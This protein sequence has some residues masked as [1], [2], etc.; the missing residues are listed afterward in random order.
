MIDQNINPNNP[1]LNDIIDLNQNCLRTNL[2]YEQSHYV[3]HDFIRQQKQ[4]ILMHV[5][6][7]SLDQNSGNLK[8]LLNS[9]D[10]N[11]SAI[12][13][14]EVWQLN[15]P[16]KIND[17]TNSFFNLRKPPKK[18]GGVGILL[19]S[20]D[21]ATRIDELCHMEK[22]IESV[23]VKLKNR[24]LIC[25]YRPPLYD[26]YSIT[27]FLDTLKNMMDFCSNNFP[28]FNISL[29]GDI[30]FNLLNNAPYI[31][32]YTDILDEKNLFL[33][34]SIPTRYD[35]ANN[36]CSIL[37]HIISTDAP[38]AKHWVICDSVSD[39]LPIFCMLP[40]RKKN[41]QINKYHE[42]R[43]FSEQ[44]TIAFKLNLINHDFSNIY[45]IEDSND[46]WTSFFE[47]FDIIF[48]N[49]F[50]LK[51]SKIKK[52]KYE[53][54]WLN[55]TLISDLKKEKKLY[56]KK[57]KTKNPRDHNIHMSFK[58]QVQKDIRKAKEHYLNNF[59][60]ENAKDSRKTWRQLNSLIDKTPKNSEP[61]TEIIVNNNKINDND[62]IA[63][64]FN[65]FFVSVGANL[66]S[67]I[68]VNRNDQAEYLRN[69][70]LSGVNKPKFKF[71][72]LSIPQVINCA[73]KI[74]PKLSRGPDGVPSK[75]AR[76]TAITI[77]EIIQH[78][79][80]SSLSSGKIHPRLKQ[81]NI[82]PLH[83]S[84]P[85][86]V[87]T[88]F[89]P[90]SL[91]NSFSKLLEKCVGVQLTAFL[92]RNNLLFPNQFGFRSK[93]STTHTML[94]F[95]K[96]LEE[97]ISNRKLASS[98]FLDLS[99]AFDT[100][101]HSIIISKLK[102]LG[103]DNIELE[104]FRDYLSHRQQSCVV[105]G[106]NSPFL[107]INIGVPQG[108]ILGPILFIIF[109][110][111]FPQFVALFTCLFADDT[112]LLSIA[113]DLNS[114][115]QI[116]NDELAKAAK[117]FSL[118]ELSIN[119][120][121]T[122]SIHFKMNEKPPFCINDVPISDIHSSN[123]ELDSKKF[124]FLGYFIDE[125]LNFK[126]HFKKVVKKLNSAIFILRSLKNTLTTKHKLLLFNAIFKSH[127]EY[128][129]LIWGTSREVEN[130]I[131]RLQRTA[132][133]LVNGSSAKIHS[134]PLFSK[135]KVLKF[136]D[137][138]I[139]QQISIAHSI[140]YEKAPVSLREAMPRVVEHEIFN[141]RR[142]TYKLQTF[143]TNR[144]SVCNQII[145]RAWNN[146]TQEQKLIEKL[147]TL[148]KE[149]KTNILNTYSTDPSCHK[150]GCRICDNNN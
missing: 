128:G 124:K 137:T 58:K 29:L 131:E 78:L 140:V 12:F 44:E 67:S 23:A 104:W 45:N 2:T 86:S 71:S 79:I 1:D 88:N 21:N 60:T 138:K 112:S 145:P 11:V 149:I 31:Q 55:P 135:F 35:F 52:K 5:N 39:H 148:K 95:L 51:R 101:S 116:T 98:I 107:D 25:S 142:N 40:S 70:E 30:N 102:S 85:K 144:N 108:S 7:R 36:S 133:L 134:E 59:F 6:I 146:L 141:L 123:E 126:S 129:A 83:K 97:A 16:C 63:H 100:T 53:D 26:S 8:N 9:I 13:L 150:R 114:L 27:K 32:R 3:D 110:N 109:I 37:D 147:S 19:K 77:P 17:Y 132:L 61:I 121:K 87:L 72:P 127:Y 34:I 139:I 74:A 103:V 80:N 75:F 143:G 125:T 24:I 57:I 118:N 117:W 94:V 47:D 73:K 43:T 76:I 82:L 119:V 64:E 106:S 84:G 136:K 115:T 18:G 66:A 96:K 15:K 120:S 38:I 81:A 65:K 20:S 111:D 50:P 46:K 42:F 122:R 91:L 14:S 41:A 89:R 49:S 48:N 68:D 56:T 93:T 10:N 54:P 22:Y 69:I 90:I 99:K 28:N 62:S 33:G 4:E 130:K 113:N 92:E 105:N